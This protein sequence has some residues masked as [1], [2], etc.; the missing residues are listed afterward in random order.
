MTKRTKTEDCYEQ[1]CFEENST[2]FDVED[3]RHTCR[4]V[5]IRPLLEK[6]PIY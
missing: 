1:Q 4:H 6:N 2:A 5:T 3:Q